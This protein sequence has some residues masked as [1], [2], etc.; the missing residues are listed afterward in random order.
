MKKLFLH[1]ILSI[2]SLNMLLGQHSGVDARRI[3]EN[4]V[5]NPVTPSWLRNNL[6]EEAPRLF[7]NNEKEQKIKK[8]LGND[9]LL[10][11]Y[12]HLLQSNADAICEQPLLKREKTG[13]RLLG[14]SR[15][16]VRRIGTLGLTYRIGKN[17]KYLE[18]LEKEMNAVCG[19]SD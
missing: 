11:H 18:R 1:I 9:P 7:L 12:F 15:K 16:A 10:K 3:R 14:V 13:R 19:F 8:D 6:K 2:F 5:E 17:E 4:V